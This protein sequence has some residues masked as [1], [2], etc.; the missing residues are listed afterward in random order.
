MEDTEMEDMRMVK[1][2][3]LVKD[4][5]RGMLEGDQIYLT[6]EPITIRNVN[7]VI[8]NSIEDAKIK[9]VPY[10]NYQME[11]IFDYEKLNKYGKIV[12]ENSQ[13]DQ[14]DRRSFVTYLAEDEEDEKN[15]ISI[16]VGVLGL[17]NISI[18]ADY[19]NR[20]S[21]DSLKAARHMIDFYRDMAEVVHFSYNFI[22]WSLFVLAVDKTDFEE[23]L[24]M[25]CDFAKMLQISD[26]EVMDIVMVIKY[27]FREETSPKFVSE[28]IPEIFGEVL[29]MYE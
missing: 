13:T 12:L 14:A 15:G 2:E 10:R 19:Q 20:E 8:S 5:N 27:I 16:P 22:F 3:T 17:D 11:L 24:S 9:H 29:K 4:V 25:I 21:I 7:E 23:K 1:F 18:R 28:D 26:E 6:G